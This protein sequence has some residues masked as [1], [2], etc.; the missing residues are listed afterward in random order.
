MVPEETEVAPVVRPSG[1]VPS[2]LKK[3]TVVK[4]VDVKPEQES[5]QSFFSFAE[6]D[7]VNDSPVDMDAVD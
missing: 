2:F 7:Q 4:E 6:D 5:L 1:G 3:P